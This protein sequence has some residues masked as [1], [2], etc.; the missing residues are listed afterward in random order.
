MANYADSL[1]DSLLVPLPK[2]SMG[3]ALISEDPFERAAMRARMAA[4]PA[5]GRREGALSEALSDPATLFN[6]SPFGAARDAMTAANEGEYGRAALTAAPLVAPLA[7]G[8]VIRGAGAALRA[9]PKTVATGAAALGLGVPTSTDEAQTA[10]PGKDWWRTP[11][12]QFQRGT[13]EAPTLTPEEEAQFVVP[14][15]K[16]PKGWYGDRETVQPSVPL[17]I[18]RARIA[19]TRK[20]AQDVQTRKADYLQKK[21]D[22]SRRDF[23]AEQARLQ[24]EYDAEQARLDAKDQEYK[25]ANQSFR[26]AHPYLAPAIQG[27]GAVTAALGPLAI[28]GLQL[29]RNNAITG[30]L[31][32]AMAG[33][34][35]AAGLEGAAGRPARIAAK[36]QLQASLGKQGIG[37]IQPTEMGIGGQIGS[38]IAGGIEGATSSVVPYI[39]DQET[40]PL[41]SHGQEESSDMA[42]WLTRAAYG[43]IPSAA[44]GVFGAR[45]PM[46]Q[47]RVP[48]VARAKGQIK[49]LGEAIKA[50][51]AAAKAAAVP[52]SRV[53]E[54]TADATVA[55]P[56]KSKVP[57]RSR[58]KKPAESEE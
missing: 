48:D 14:E 50:D 23:E 38:G 4:R 32:K 20:Q 3:D 44:M 6:I 21:I 19:D 9:A 26:E 39:I 46:S 1:W 57:S 56:A 40:L 58:K 45:L 29:R 54:S 24:A 53:V 55:A 10:E 41:G 22:T 42:N 36:E 16:K 11:R 2:E 35:Y 15:W 25:I 5:G 33:G 31:D 37:R 8:P 28:R 51:T 34:D 49:G 47:G 27:A 52:K 18:E 7:A 17:S 43:A 30:Q 13:F 12:E